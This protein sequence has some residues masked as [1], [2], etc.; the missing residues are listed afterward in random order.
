[1]ADQVPASSGVSVSII[2]S[3]SAK[4]NNPPAPIPRKMTA[5]KIGIGRRSKIRP[6]SSDRLHKM[7]NNFGFPNRVTTA[8]TRSATGI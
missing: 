1:M 4:G 5:G 8:G 6:I 3:I 2:G 7:R